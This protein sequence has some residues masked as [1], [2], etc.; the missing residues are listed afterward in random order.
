[1]VKGVRFRLFYRLFGSLLLVALGTVAVLGVV[2]D[3]NVRANARTQFEDRLSYESTMLGQM[4]ATALFGPLDET[5]RSLQNDITALGTAVHTRLSLVTVDGKVV[6]DSEEQRSAPTAAAA[7]G[8]ARAQG[9]GAA[10]R[11]GRIYVARAIVRDGKVLGFARS[12]VPAAL[13][14]GYVH[15]VRARMAWGALLAILAAVAAGFAVSRSIAG[16]V[17]QLAESARRIGAGD[18]QGAVAVIRND[19][20]GDLATAFRDMQ[21]SLGETMSA[22]DARNRDMRLVLDNIQQGLFTVNLD[23]HISQERSAVLTRWLGTPR[24]PLI[25]EY[26]ARTD[27]AAAARF[28]MSFEA[29]VEDLMPLE[30]NLAQMPRRIAVAAR[31]YDVEYQP[32]FE[33]AALDKLLVV[34]SDVTERLQR[35]AREA[36][37]CEMIA[38][39]EHLNRDRVG[40]SRFF[41]EAEGMVGTLAGSVPR[42]LV[43]EKRWLHTLKGNAGL[44]GLTSLAT[45]CHDLEQEIAES[46]VAI[47][48]EG[49]RRLSAAWTRIVETPWG[50][51]ALTSGGRRIEIDESDLADVL[52]ALDSGATAS[53]LSRLVLAWRDE[54]V[55]S[56]LDVL[57][58]QA[59]ALA[60]RLE[61]GPL[62]VEVDASDLRCP[63]GVCDTFWSNL[64]HVIRNAVDHGLEGSTAR[65]A[66]GKPEA[67][68]ISLRARREG[69]ALLVSVEDD[70][71]GVDWRAIAR[72]AVKVDMPADSHEALVAALFADG[73][74]TRS[75]VTETSGR[76]VGLAAVQVAVKSLGGDIRVTSSTGKGTRFDFRIPIAAFATVNVMRRSVPAPAF[77]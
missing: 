34:V 2:V 63:P 64:V 58:R 26:L 15:D 7:R 51:Q 24:S 17:K 61:K 19:E 45:V 4:M 32:I 36:E 41:T 74:T 5:D 56:R 46:G 57:A 12:S 1:M 48:D 60:D 59:E 35:E 6:A 39:F 28:Q 27:P 20:I 31:R 67:A 72:H 10:A 66:A 18:F 69:G 38:I 54:R 9:V 68:K 76:G 40:V 53:E 49:K 22:L 75:S 43:D 77:H 16:P 14:D 33:G 29:V 44:V 52:R 50:R 11:D 37:Q 73:V 71:C 13:V 3:R 62:R 21:R 30:L 70:G 23:G 8:L 42:A 55:Q 65:L 25:W 47:G